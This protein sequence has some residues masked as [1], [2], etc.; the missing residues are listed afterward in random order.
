MEEDG[1]IMLLLDAAK[2]LHDSGD[3]HHDG[4]LLQ[5]LEGSGGTA[6]SA[7]MFATRPPAYASVL[8]LCSTGG[9]T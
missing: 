3:H 2:E 1:N 9:N 7:T 4:E 5:G 6:Q 8:D